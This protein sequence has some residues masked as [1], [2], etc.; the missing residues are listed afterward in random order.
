MR[1]ILIQ[2]NLF[3]TYLLACYHVNVDMWGPPLVKDFTPN[4]EWRLHYDAWPLLPIDIYPHQE[5]YFMTP[6]ITLV[7]MDWIQPHY[8]IDSSN[9]IVSFG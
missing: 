9:V 2:L 4:Y 8:S 7:A 6:Q 3:L 1:L 5:L